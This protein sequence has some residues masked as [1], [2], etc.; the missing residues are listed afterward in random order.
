[1]FDFLLVTLFQVAAGAPA[2]QPTVEPAPT[3]AEQQQ[4][5]AEERRCRARRLTGTRLS[6]L[7]VCR[8]TNGRQSQ[9]ARDSLHDLQRP[10]GTNAG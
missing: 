4:Q 9:D 8:R 6:S 5:E 1:M 3:E 7:V 2:P 10:V